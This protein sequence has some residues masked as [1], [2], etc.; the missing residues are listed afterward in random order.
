L[1]N[2]AHQSGRLAHTLFRTIPSSS[3]QSSIMSAVCGS[4]FTLQ[5]NWSN[6]GCH[7]TPTLLA[8]SLH[9]QSRSP[10]WLSH[11]VVALVF[12]A[13]SFSGP[14]SL[15]VRFGLG[16][17][18]NCAPICDAAMLATLAVA[19]FGLLSKADHAFVFSASHSHASQLVR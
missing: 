17:P 5:P 3:L 2:T 8:R 11:F 14:P 10:T 6:H 7:L 1:L 13:S 15:P 4:P 9:L 19:D 18:P 12:S 16:L